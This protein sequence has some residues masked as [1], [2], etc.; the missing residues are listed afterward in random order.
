MLLPALLPRVG[1]TAS[2]LPDLALIAVARFGPSLAAV[3]LVFWA[4]VRQLLVRALDVRISPRWQ[5]PTLLLPPALAA[6]AS[7]LWVV[8]V[9][10]GRL[11][12]YSSSRD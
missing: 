9:V 7:S 10:Q 8:G 6:A 4:V 12:R 3:V 1:L 5:L 11:C 2:P